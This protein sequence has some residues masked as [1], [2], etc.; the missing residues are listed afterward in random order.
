MATTVPPLRA[1]ECQVWWARRTAASRP[2]LDIL[3]ARERERWSRFM[4]EEDKGLYL[5]AHATLRL[6][7]AAHSGAVAPAIRFS[8]ICRFCGAT[9]GKPRLEDGAGALEFS[10]SH[11]GLY[12]VVAVCRAVPLGIDVEQVKPE[13]DRTR[14]IE[15]VLSDVERRAIEALPAEQQGLAFLRYWTRKEAMLKATGHGLAVPLKSVTVSAHDAA[16]ALLSWAAEPALEAPAQLLD[17]AAPSGHLAA[18]AL[19][20]E[21]LDVVERDAAPLLAGPNI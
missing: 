6:V 13:R 19:L 11:S 10:L 1:G 12:A 7:L 8:T 4:R 5:V 15:G 17:L 18:L 14:L 3:D 20:G 16:P 21:R 9:H 2:L